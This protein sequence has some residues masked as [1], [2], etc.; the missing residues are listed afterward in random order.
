M[1]TRLECPRDR[2]SITQICRAPVL[3]TQADY[4]CD[5]EITPKS[6][7]YGMLGSNANWNRNVSIE[8]IALHIPPTALPDVDS[9]ALPARVV[10]P[11]C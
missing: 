4:R 7:R 6:N 8:A 3:M 11:S 5:G 2:F 1:R 10:G 9:G